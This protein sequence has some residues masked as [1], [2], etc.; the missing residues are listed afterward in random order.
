M[1][2]NH[3]NDILYTNLGYNDHNHD[4]L[5]SLKT[6]GLQVLLHFTHTAHLEE[7]GY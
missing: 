1:H 6:L 7:L 4:M 5:Y 2:N 3:N